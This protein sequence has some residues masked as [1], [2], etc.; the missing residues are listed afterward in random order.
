[1]R[2]FLIRKIFIKTVG[3][4]IYQLKLPEQYRKLYKTFHISLFKPY[5]RKAGEEPPKLISFNK[6][7]RYQVESIR[8]ERI[9]KNKI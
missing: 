5:I 6:N 4:N 8:K 3:L 9:S 1:M 2:F 7:N